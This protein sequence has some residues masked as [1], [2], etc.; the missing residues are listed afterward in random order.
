MSAFQ[1]VKNTFTPTEKQQISTPTPG[2]FA[3]SN[4][5]TVNL[6]DLGQNDFSFPLPV[7][8]ARLNA[9]HLSVDITSKQGD[10]VKAAF[11]GVVRLSKFI[12]GQGN[13]IV[14][15]HD[16]GI[17]TVYARNAQNL[18]Q[19]EERV[20]AGQTIAIIGGQDKHI[21]CRFSI[22]VNGSPINPTTLIDIKSHRLRPQLVTFIK[23][24][25]HINVLVENKKKTAEKSTD[26]AQNDKNTPNKYSTEKQTAK[27][28]AA[29]NKNELD[30]SLLQSHEWRYPLPNAKV[31]SPYG[32]R[33][34]HA[35]VDIKTKPN[36]KILAAFDGT[37]IQSGPYHGYGNFIV[38]KHDNGLETRYS[39]QSKNLV[40]VGDKVKAGDVI[41]LTGRTGR[42]TTEHLHF[43]VAY[44]GRRI[45][46]ATIFNYT[47]QQLKNVILRW[48]NGRVNV[49]NK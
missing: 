48:V 28:G 31:I 45:N 36:D 42:A 22:M 37:V 34:N 17:E 29:N 4:T 43:E 41:G 2:L 33:R 47:T 8:K 25:K 10:A 49:L 1:P 26:I 32:G 11:A 12:P 30:L 19:V 18:V 46:P 14:V 13:V 16:N 6:A 7:G 39:H 5:I 15:R 40:K 24:G 35:G 20:Q 3:K 27:N 44:K 38:I 23:K 9:N 21:F